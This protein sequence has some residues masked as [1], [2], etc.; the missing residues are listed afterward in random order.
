MSGKVG[1]LLEATDSFH[2]NWLK[3]EWVGSD[4][5][6]TGLKNDPDYFAKGLTLL[7]S[8][9][10]ALDECAKDHPDLTRFTLTSIE[11]ALGGVAGYIRTRVNDSVGLT[12][13]VTDNV[14]R[15]ETWISKH[16]QSNL[17]MT[18]QKA[19]FLAGAGSFGMLFGLGVALGGI[20]EKVLKKAEDVAGKVK[21]HMTYFKDHPSGKSPYTGK[22]S[23]MVRSVDDLDGIRRILINR[24]RN[25]HMNRAG[26]GP[27]RPDKVTVNGDAIRGREQHNIN[28]LGGAQSTGGSSSNKNNS[29]HHKNPKK[30][31]YESAHQ[32]E[33][34]E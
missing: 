4:I 15:T 11:L 27:A 7:S 17:E 16:L 25:H 22:T 10:V 32:R 18:S 33:F 21:V 29:I 3:A 24:D 31:T 28:N 2:K 23:G 1:R 9:A 13:F 5:S 6:F 12:D 8:A 14:N 26:F 20:K 19:D 30:G 34:S